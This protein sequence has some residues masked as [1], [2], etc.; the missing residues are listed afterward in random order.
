M[1]QAGISGGHVDRTNSGPAR[2]MHEDDIV[3]SIDILHRVV[4]TPGARRGCGSY[5][6]GGLP[7]RMG[8]NGDGARHSNRPRDGVRRP[9]DPENGVPIARRNT[10][11]MGRMNGQ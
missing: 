7:V 11:D 10:P 8:N 2:D 9:T 1:E 4:G 5:W 3:E 6:A